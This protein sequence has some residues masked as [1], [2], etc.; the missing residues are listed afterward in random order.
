M[1]KQMSAVLALSLALTMTACVPQNVSQGPGPK[2]APVVAET[3]AIPE[4]A[5]PQTAAEGTAP[6]VS[7]ETMSQ[8]V[9]EGTAAVP[10]AAAPTAAA[11]NVTRYDGQGYTIDI[12]DGQWR[13]ESEW[14]DGRLEQTWESIFY[15][16]AE[17]EV[18]YYAGLTKEQA[19]TAVTLDE[20]DFRLET[21]TD[22]SLMG[23]DLGDREI[24]FVRF[25]PGDNGT[26]VLT[27]TYTDTQEMADSVGAQ[28]A[29]MA[30]SFQVK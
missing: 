19:Q 27:Y 4:T 28:L 15:P 26:Y 10:E 25:Y 8:A 22:G 23:R 2:Q 17:L 9:T 1:K 7:A 13:L 11:A 21:Q 12:P 6:A 16:E 20:D 5:V 3:S 30:D 18:Q 29:S 14:D 24:L